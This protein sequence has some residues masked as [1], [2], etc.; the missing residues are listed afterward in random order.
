MVI[1]MLK[2][3]EVAIDGFQIFLCLLI[4]FLMVRNHRRKMKPEL[5]NPKSDPGQDF[6]IQVF[7]QTI[8]QQVELAFANILKA[9]ANERRDLV[10]VLQLQQFTDADHGSSGVHPP[11]LTSTPDETARNVQESAGQGDRQTRIQNLS[12]QGM[13]A[14]QI[15]EELKTPL[16]EVELILSLQKNRINKKSLI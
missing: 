13:N 12:T 10:K 15:S 5:V 16:G 7:S 8:N 6:N 11:S 4:L 9:A 3:W 2:H 14:K 1:E